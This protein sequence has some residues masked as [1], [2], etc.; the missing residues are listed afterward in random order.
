MTAQAIEASGIDI[1]FEDDDIIV[2]EKPADLL[3]VPGK[4]IEGQNCLSNR[5]LDY[6]AQSRVIHRLDMATSGLM[7]F[8]KHAAAQKHIGLQFERRQVEKA[9]IAVVDGKSDANGT[10]DLPLIADWPNRPKQK[11][12]FEQ[13]K[14]AT[15]EYQ[16]LAYDKNINTSRLLLKPQTGR[17]HQLRVHMMSIGHPIVGDVFYAHSKALAKSPRL[18]LHATKVA[19]KHPINNSAICFES[20]P[21]F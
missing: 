4:G 3:S 8:A 14:Q 17:S 6:C 1:V 16:R 18:L 21:V 5:L 10:I 15:T 12:C 13:G 11:V 7:I 20:E 19:F 9:Y 2:L